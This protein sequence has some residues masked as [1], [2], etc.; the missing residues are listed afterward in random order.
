[1]R[2]ALKEKGNRCSRRRRGLDGERNRGK[3]KA[4]SNRGEVIISRTKK[5]LGG[6]GTLAENKGVGGRKR[7]G[8]REETARK[9]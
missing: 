7:N 6:E 3:K 8:K 9:R 1:M 2:P 4:F 5:E